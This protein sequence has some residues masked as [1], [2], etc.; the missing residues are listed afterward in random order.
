MLV[1]CLDVEVEVDVELRLMVGL[2]QPCRENALLSGAMTL[3]GLGLVD[4]RS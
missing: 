3:T 2:L 1:W 4:S